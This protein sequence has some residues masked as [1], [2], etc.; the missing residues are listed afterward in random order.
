[1]AHVKKDHLAASG[2]WWKHLRGTKRRFWKK[3]RK[4]EIREARPA[5]RWSHGELRAHAALDVVRRG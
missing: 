5:N 4:A 2:E 1:M 3:H